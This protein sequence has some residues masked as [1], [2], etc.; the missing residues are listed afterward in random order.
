MRTRRGFSMV[1][2][3][4]IMIIIS[5]LSAIAV[6]RLAQTA[7]SAQAA[8]L[9]ATLTNVGEAIEMYYAEHGRYP[10]YN[11]ANG[12]P[13]GDRF[14]DQMLEYSDGGGWTQSA[15]AY[16]Y[17]YGPYLRDRFPINP[18]NGL[19]TV[20]VVATRATTVPL[21][22]SGWIAVLST[23]EFRLNASSSDFESI[24][25]TEDLAGMGA[26]LEG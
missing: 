6:P 22:A 18:F 8:S 7:A 5:L 24:G 20:R 17:I 10:G 4:M 15:M 14:H 12:A 9:I 23:G 3:M 21:G 16:P 11:P 25:L 26:Q 1:E 19:D 2:M 13:D